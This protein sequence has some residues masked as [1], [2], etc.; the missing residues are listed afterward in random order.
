VVGAFY[1][2]RP[3]SGHPSEEGTAVADYTHSLARCSAQAREVG[4]AAPRSTPSA[5]ADT[6]RPLVMQHEGRSTARRMHLET[7]SCPRRGPRSRR[8][9]PITP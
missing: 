4:S 2:P 5:I 9:A 8:L 3:R 6:C 7:P 1:P